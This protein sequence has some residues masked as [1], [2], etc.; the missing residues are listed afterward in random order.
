MNEYH[1]Q[2]S[3]LAFGLLIASF[4]Y[5]TDRQ[6]AISIMAVVVILGVAIA[7]AIARGYHVPLFSWIIGRLERDSVYPGMGS[8]VFFIAAL[9]CLIIFGSQ[10]TVAALIVLSVL[11]SI[12]TAVGLKFGKTKIYGKKT[13][14][15]AM[16]GFFA[17]IAALAIYTAMIP[18]ALPLGAVSIIVA[19]GIGAITEL[20]SPVDDNITI[21]VVVGIVLFLIV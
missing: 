17:S 2:L 9:F 21:P 10:I 14:E 1:R 18:D 13:L 15:G 8:M 5:F 12:S 4:I 3:H 7:D 20:I 6:I 11:D 19:S 16:G